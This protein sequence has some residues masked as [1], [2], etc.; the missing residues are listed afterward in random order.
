MLV[1]YTMET[2]NG[3]ADLSNNRVNPDGNTP[4]V[5]EVED[6]TAT[7]PA[8]QLP[9]S[10]ANPSVPC[11]GLP[12]IHSES[13]RRYIPT[14]P[15]HNRVASAGLRVT[16]PEKSD[17]YN[18]ALCRPS[19]YVYPVSMPTGPEFF[20]FIPGPMIPYQGFQCSIPH[21]GVIP[22]FI[23]PGGS[24]HP[25]AA[26]TDSMSPLSL[27]EP[28]LPHSVPH[29]GSMLPAGSILFTMDDWSLIIPRPP[30]SQGIVLDST[31]WMAMP[32]FPQ[33]SLA[34][35]NAATISHSQTVPPGQ[36]DSSS[37]QQQ[38]EHPTF[39]EQ[40]APET[41]RT[42]L[43]RKSGFVEPV[44]APDFVTNSDNHDRW[45]VDDYGRWYLLNVLSN[46]KRRLR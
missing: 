28:M 34:G 2:R 30:F 37:Q 7:V 26:P 31:L 22:G 19:G 3:G 1:T 35:S 46:K 33:A 6:A 9:I 39:P 32:N 24:I 40:R 11:Q 27:P 12:T 17:Y 45:E 5:V 25:I 23:P 41:Q 18:Y 20:L 10:P 29:T 44:V 38:N 21:A 14:L 13:S 43:K 36:G 15:R 8:T 42:A 4:K 16:I